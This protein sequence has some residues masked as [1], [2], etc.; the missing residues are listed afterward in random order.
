MLGNVSIKSRLCMDTKY[1]GSVFI[2]KYSNFLESKA[3][4]LKNKNKKPLHFLSFA[5]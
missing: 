4:K 2:N 1:V 3:E 5:G